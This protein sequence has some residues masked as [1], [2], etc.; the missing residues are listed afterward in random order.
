MNT[1]AQKSGPTWEA[2]SQESEDSLAK[3]RIFVISSKQ[4]QRKH[5]CALSVIIIVEPQT[6]L[7]NLFIIGTTHLA[8][9]YRSKRVI[10]ITSFIRQ[11]TITQKESWE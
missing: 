8:Y 5:K 11:A 3:E 4:L 1:E 9:M 2:S 10:S 6:S 7:I